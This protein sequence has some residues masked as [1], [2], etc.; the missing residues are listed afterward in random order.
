MWMLEG[1]TTQVREGQ[2]KALTSLGEA[3]VSV[4]PTFME[5]RVELLE[6]HRRLGTGQA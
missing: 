6:N 2:F 5:Q 1:L 3:E 4:A